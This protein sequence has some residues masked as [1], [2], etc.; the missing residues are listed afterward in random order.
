MCSINFIYNTKLSQDELKK[1]IMS[2]VKITKHRGPDTTECITENNYSLGFNRL[3]LVGGHLGK[4]PIIDKK[5]ELILICN[6]EIFNHLDLKKDYFPNEKFLTTSD[7]EIII[8]L[9]KKFGVQSISYLEGQFSFVL[10]DIKKQEFFFGRDKFGINPLF[11]Y[12]KNNTFIISSEIKSILISKLARNISLNQQGLVDTLFF[13][14]A[15]PPKTCFTNIYQ[16]PPASFGVFNIHKSKL[17]VNS[18]WD[19]K[20][21]KKEYLEIKATKKELKQTLYKSVDKRLQGNSTT[22]IYLS[23]GLDSS[24]IAMITSKL[25]KKMQLFSIAFEDKRYDESHYQ[26]QIAN[27]LGMKVNQVSI[28]LDDIVKFLDICIFHAE[29]PLIRTAPVPMLL[30]S[31]AVRKAGIKYVLCGEGADEMFAGY[32]VFLKG[33]ASFEDK[34]SVIKPYVNIFK[35]KQLISYAQKTY[36]SLSFSPTNSNLLTQVRKKEIHT[37]LSQ[38]LLVNQGDRMSMANGIEQRFPFLDTDVVNFAFSLDKRLLIGKDNGKVILRNTFKNSLP[39]Q[40]ITR[41]KQGY[42]AP[43]EDVVKKLLRTKKY[44][45]L[46]EESF[47]KKVNIFDFRKTSIIINKIKNNIPFELFDINFILFVFTTHSLYKIFI[48]DIELSNNTKKKIH[49]VLVSAK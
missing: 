46:L 23:G 18:Y 40:I 24:I 38:Y 1:A 26:K 21:F 47:F 7:V 5:N 16:I 44:A 41:R 28:S 22:G 43:D 29:T 25:A 48:E 3:A 10:F 30:L 11:Y 32:P 33:Q 49:E 36:T 8:H 34:W 14:G 27:M 15:V 6:G 2:M 19:I 12:Q 42:L 17:E 37:K 4:Q 45:Y 31:R 9:Y 20:Q 39:K 13:Y 35:E